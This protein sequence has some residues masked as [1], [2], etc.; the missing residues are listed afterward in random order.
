MRS[1][2]LWVGPVSSFFDFLTFYV[3]LHVFRANESLFHRGWFVESLRQT[4]FLLVIRTIGNP[5]RSRPSGASLLSTAA[6]VMV[7]FAL[8]CAPIAH[9]FGFTSCPLSLSGSYLCLSLDR[10][11]LLKSS[12]P[13]K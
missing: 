9:D 13:V 2:M 12:T 7:A 10:S 8:T 3:L 4:L 5:L 1:F 6:I 11:R